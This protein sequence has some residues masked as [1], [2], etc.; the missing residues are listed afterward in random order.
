MHLSVVAEK[1]VEE[2]G[3]AEVVEAAE[4]V[5]VGRV[6][7]TGEPGGSQPPLMRHELP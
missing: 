7:T 1:N 5:E 3:V 6:R 4:V 2:V